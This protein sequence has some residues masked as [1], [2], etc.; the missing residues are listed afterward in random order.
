[1]QQDH[2]PPYVLASLWARFAGNFIDSLII[3]IVLIPIVYF[4]GGFDMMMESQPAEPSLAQNVGAAIAGLAVYAVVNW[5]SLEK[6]GQTVGK[7]IMG[8]KIVFLDGTQAG[9]ADV[10]LKRYAVYLLL[11]HVPYVGGVISLIGLLL[12]FGGQQR[13]LHDRV[14]GTKVVCS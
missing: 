1:M 11:P 13:C 7:R 2:T 6:D 10:V 3:G 4:A 12:I 14:A 8:T 9:A 5:K